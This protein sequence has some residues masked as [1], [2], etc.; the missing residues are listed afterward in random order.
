MIYNLRGQMVK[1]ADSS[2]YETFKQSIGEKVKSPVAFSLILKY[3]KSQHPTSACK[4]TKADAGAL[5][6][7]A[8]VHMFQSEM[9]V[10]ARFCL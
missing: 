10:S 8:M 5:S 3:M 4:W 9:N 1:S 6:T 2:F 7:P